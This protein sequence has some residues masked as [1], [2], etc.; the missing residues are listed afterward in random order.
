V[1]ELVVE[2]MALQVLEEE[3][4][5]RIVPTIILELVAPVELKL[6]GD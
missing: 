2:E 6:E 3:P 5:V 4:L 1:E